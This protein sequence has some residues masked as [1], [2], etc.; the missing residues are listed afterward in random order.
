MKSFCAILCFLSLMLSVGECSGRSSHGGATGASEPVLTIDTSHTGLVIY[1]PIYTKIDLVCDTMPSK[2]D[3][4]VILCCEAAYTGDATEV[5]RHGNILGDHVSSG[6]RYKGIPSRRCTGAFIYY[7]GFHR[8]V[9]RDLSAALDEAAAGGGMGFCQEMLVHEGAEVE[10]ARKSTS[11]NYFRALCEL[12]GR[13]CVVDSSE[14]ENFGSF[15][16]KLKDLGVSEA[17]YLDMGMG[18]NHSW[19]RLY[20]GSEAVDIYPWAHDYTTNWITFYST[21]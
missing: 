6:Q 15:M 10:H 7:G 19:Y 13:V 18:W 4:S 9:Y 12:D 1:Y 20:P 21:R 11:K 8:F 2:N 3:A 16:N 14:W 17:L 5:F